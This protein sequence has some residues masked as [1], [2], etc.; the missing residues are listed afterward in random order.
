M[1]ESHLTVEAISDPWVDEWPRTMP[2][3]ELELLRRGVEQR[4]AVRER[5]SRCRRTPLIGERIYLVDGGAVLC[6]LC[7]ASESEPPL[8][9]R[10][11]RGPALGRGI[12]VLDERA[13]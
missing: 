2:A 4:D 5:C 8:R 3:L 13:A 6:E 11:V 10:R 9:S 7:C 1:R 12:R